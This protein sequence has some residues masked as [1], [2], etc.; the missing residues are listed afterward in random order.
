MR[1]FARQQGAAHCGVG[2]ARIGS[3][4]FGGGAKR[5]SSA[6][7]LTRM[8]RPKLGWKL[9]AYSLALVSGGKQKQP[10]IGQCLCRS[11]HT[12]MLATTATALAMPLI[13]RPMVCRTNDSVGT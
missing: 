8:E 12:V 3:V 10:R 6:S 4:L 1:A 5:F 9:G 7:V 11:R 2:H 13:S